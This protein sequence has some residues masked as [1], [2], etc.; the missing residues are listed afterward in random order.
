[1]ARRRGV[2]RRPPV[3]SGRSR[4]CSGAACRG[5]CR[6]VPDWKEKMRKEKVR[7]EPRPVGIRAHLEKNRNHNRDGGNVRYWTF[8]SDL[9][10]KTWRIT[11]IVEYNEPGNCCT[12]L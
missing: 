8:D 10:R 6:R 9:F 4:T 2:G 3:C 1:M 11:W 7:R 5:P 12:K